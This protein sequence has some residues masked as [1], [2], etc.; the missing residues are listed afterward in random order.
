ME[1]QEEIRLRL[2]ISKLEAQVE[3]C[4]IERVDLKRILNSPRTSPAELSE[5]LQRAEILER[6]FAK[7]SQALKELRSTHPNLSRR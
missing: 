3:L 4:D 2:R 7:L 6:D 1:F 5:A